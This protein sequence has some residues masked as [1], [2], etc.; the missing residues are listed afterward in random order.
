MQIQDLG[1]DLMKQEYCSV[2]F[3][4]GPA[5]YTGEPLVALLDE[6][7][8]LVARRE[9]TSDPCSWRMLADH[10]APAFYQRPDGALEVPLNSD[11]ISPE[12]PLIMAESAE[13]TRKMPRPPHY[14]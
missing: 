3:Y 9:V 4:S 1:S 8:G 6:L 13:Q 2:W 11:S 14:R 12:L 5:P 7:G 10:E